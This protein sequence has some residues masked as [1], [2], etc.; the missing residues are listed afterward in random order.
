MPLQCT[1]KDLKRRCCAALGV[2]E[3]D[4][5]IMDF[6][7]MDKATKASLL[8]TAESSCQLLLWQTERLR[9]RGLALTFLSPRP[10]TC[11][12]QLEDKWVKTMR[13]AEA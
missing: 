4:Y 10:R 9:N 11:L 8:A 12:P 6:Y 3:D 1:V 7:G 13:G 2:A 5:V